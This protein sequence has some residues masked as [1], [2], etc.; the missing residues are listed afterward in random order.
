MIN[1]RKHLSYTQVDVRIS[2]LYFLQK[3]KYG[4]FIFPS[5]STII[6]KKCKFKFENKL[7]EITLANILTSNLNVSPV[8]LSAL[9]SLTFDYLAHAL[10]FK[11]NVKGDLVMNATIKGYCLCRDNNENRKREITQNNDK[12]YQKIQT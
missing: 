10:P 4:N 1:V 7:Y 8:Q 3:N 6:D 2:K 5:K 11:I 12:H 9:L